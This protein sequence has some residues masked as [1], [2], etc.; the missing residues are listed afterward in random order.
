MQKSHP[1]PLTPLFSQK[2]KIIINI[3]IIYLFIYL[4]M[5]LLHVNWE[6]TANNIFD[7]TQ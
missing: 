3:I 5:Y 1:S 2:A 7:V 4:Y 6:I